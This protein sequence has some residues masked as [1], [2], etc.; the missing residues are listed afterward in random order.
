MLPNL[1]SL[2]LGTPL[3]TNGRD[4]LVKRL[5]K[6]AQE[7]IPSRSRA[8][9]RPP[10]PP[11]LSPPRPDDYDELF[12]SDSDGYDTDDYREYFMGDF[13]SPVVPMDIEVDA[14][15]LE[16]TVG[17]V[18]KLLEG[19]VTR[20]E[21]ME[22]LVEIRSSAAE[23]WEALVECYRENARMV[24][25]ERQ[26]AA[27][28]GD[29]TADTPAPKKTSPKNGIPVS[30]QKIMVLLATLMALI[31]FKGPELITSVDEEPMGDDGDV[32]TLRTQPYAPTLPETPALPALPPP[33]KVLRPGIT[34][35]RRGPGSYGPKPSFPLRPVPQPWRT[36]PGG[37]PGVPP[38]SPPPLP[39]APEPP[40]KVV[41]PKPSDSLQPTPGASLEVSPSSPPPLPATPAPSSVPLAPV[42]AEWWSEYLQR[43]LMT[44]GVGVVV[45]AVEKP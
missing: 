20:K 40:G 11:P 45:M 24:E 7:A 43:S 41:G 42:E 30:M 16:S 22:L 39:A 27:S 13:E 35:R 5:T 29:A 14:Q 18:T 4:D 25:T 44:L 15:V 36:T 38:S 34:R 37:S 2:S 31:S 1:S 3:N 6:A 28:E 26:R 10:M 23:L 9:P 12:V 8:P 33:G 32:Y 21:T 19:G 17:N